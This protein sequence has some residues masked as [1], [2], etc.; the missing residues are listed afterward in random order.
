MDL[1]NLFCVTYFVGGF[2]LYYAVYIYMHIFIIL[3]SNLSV[4]YNTLEYIE[5][6]SSNDKER[7]NCLY[8]MEFRTILSTT[9][10]KQW[11]LFFCRR[12]FGSELH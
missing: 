11:Y 6:L 8:L 9:K 10:N 2:K 5:S 12:Q 1:Q 7:N 4:F 3:D